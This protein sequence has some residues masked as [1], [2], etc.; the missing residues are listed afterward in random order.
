MMQVVIAACQ[1]I[2]RRLRILL[3]S[4]LVVGVAIAI[5]SQRNSFQQPEEA[6]QNLLP[7]RVRQAHVVTRE[8]VAS[9]APEAGLPVSQGVAT[10]PAQEVL[11]HRESVAIAREL[12][13]LFRPHS[14]MMFVKPKVEVAP[15]PPPK[16]TAPPVPYTLFGRLRDV[17]GKVVVYLARDGELL[18]IRVGQQ[19]HNTYTVDSISQTEIVL[20]YLPLQ[21]KQVL[22]IAPINDAE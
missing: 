15:P 4:A 3:L 22:P 5:D 10:N 18:P 9:V 7:P 19:L 21:E 2:P 20:T 6:A 1:Q 8:S 13:D 14:W 17:N 11:Q 16:P 12:S